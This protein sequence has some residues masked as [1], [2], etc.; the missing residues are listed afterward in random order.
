MKKLVP[1]AS[2]LGHLLLC[3][4]LVQ[5]AAGA[6][7]PAPL[8]GDS[9]LQIAGTFTD[10][11]NR[12]FHLVDR[13]GT[14]QLISMFYGSCQSICPL[15]IE[16]GAAITHALSPAERRRLNVLLVT[17]DPAR[18]SPKVLAQVAHDHRVDLARWTLARTDQR[19]VRQ[20]AAALDVR[21]RKLESGDF[22]HTTVWVLL[23]ANGRMVARTENL[24]IEPDATFVAAVRSTL[25][26]R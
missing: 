10:Q 11:S 26:E 21:Y 8:P 14:P 7:E 2:L 23:D 3:W 4:V 12:T 18:D 22:N 24:T 25:R 17:L 20:L 9:V 6:A 15:L 19:V 1:A 16:T 5:G 13:R